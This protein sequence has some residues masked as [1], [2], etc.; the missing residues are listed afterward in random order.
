VSDC[1]SHFDF[2]PLFCEPQQKRHQLEGA[3]DPFPS[4]PG[5]MGPPPA[6]RSRSRQSA[7]EELNTGSHEEFP[8]LSPSPVAS[9]QPQPP[10]SA[11]SVRPRIKP[12]GVTESFT[13]QDVDLSGAGKDG[14]PKTLAEITKGIMQKYKVKLEASTNRGK[15][16]TFWLK[17]ESQRELDRAKNALIADCSPVVTLIVQAPASTISS[18]IGTKGGI[19]GFAFWP[20][21]LIFEL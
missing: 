5:H 7:Q 21:P 12:S 10:T 17:S 19:V 11:W 13:L 18:I 8:S 1:I 4:L 16:T 20:S 15:E 3:P 2:T 9:T 14:R 6:A